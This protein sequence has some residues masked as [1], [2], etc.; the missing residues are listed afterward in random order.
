MSVSRWVGSP[1]GWG[2]TRPASRVQHIS[3]RSIGKYRRGLTPVEIDTV[4]KI[5]G[6][7]MERLGYC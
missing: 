6:P 2:S 7:T 4:M 5:A 3:S 1:S